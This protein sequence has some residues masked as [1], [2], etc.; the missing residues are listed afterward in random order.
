MISMPITIN[1][2]LDGVLFQGTEKEFLEITNFNRKEWRKNGNLHRTD[3]PALICMDND[4]KQ[5]G[6][7]RQ[8]FMPKSYFFID[9]VEINDDVF[10]LMKKHLVVNKV[11]DIFSQGS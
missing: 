7:Y 8:K 3:G 2:Y 6:M 9:G 10:H 5:A 1:L 4:V 11:I